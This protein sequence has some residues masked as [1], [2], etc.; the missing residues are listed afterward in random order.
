MSK[1][2]IGKIPISPSTV[3]VAACPF[4]LNCKV[5]DIPADGR[6]PE[7][8]Q[9]GSS[10]H[11]I[12]HGINTAKTMND[13]V[14]DSIV[15]TYGSQN[16][17]H[18]RH[19]ALKYMGYFPIKKVIASE[20]HLA[21]DSNLK[22]CAWDAGVYRGI[23]DAILFDV[24][25]MDGYP[26]MFAREITICDHKAGWALQNPTTL[27]TLFYLWLVWRSFDFAFDSV[28]LMKHF[29]RYK[30][31]RISKRTYVESDMPNIERTMLAAAQQVWNTPI[32]GMAIPGAQ[33]DNCNWISQCPV[34]DDELAVIIDEEDAIKVASKIRVME[35][36]MKDL[37]KQLKG[38]AEIKGPV[39]LYDHEYCYGPVTSTS[40][41]VDPAELLNKRS[42]WNDL[43]DYL[44]VN[45][46]DAKAL[47]DH[48]AGVHVDIGTKATFR[49]HKLTIKNDN[50]ED[51]FDTLKA[52]F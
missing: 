36:M 47:L 13:E 1:G 52:T 15:A 28:R 30:E 50:E 51:D 43:D 11:G 40:Y 46:A 8:S 39:T 31:I 3:G 33:C 27:Q 19:L 25:E 38:W 34:P 18:M 41:R 5:R 49:G 2:T 23:I 4:A 37:K 7:L 9:F 35:V 14:L 24:V 21:I 29:P 48:P 44:S 10:M 26:G 16:M 12:F 45:N 17:E 42:K 22:P 32:D 6:D 20:L